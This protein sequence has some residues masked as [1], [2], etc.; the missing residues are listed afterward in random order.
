MTNAF[1]IFMRYM[2]RELQVWVQTGTCRLAFTVAL[3]IVAKANTTPV[4]IS[5]CKGKDVTDSLPKG[6]DL[7]CAIT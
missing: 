3:V 5:R 6:R 2:Y 7:T 1:Q 4:W